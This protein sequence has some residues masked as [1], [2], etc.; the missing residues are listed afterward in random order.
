MLDIRKNTQ[1]CVASKISLQLISQ[2]KTETN[3]LQLLV[4]I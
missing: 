1:T 4:A 3:V 2:T